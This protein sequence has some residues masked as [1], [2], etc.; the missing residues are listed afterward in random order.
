MH[1]RPELRP[2]RPRR[3]LA[4]VAAAVALAVAGG[5]AL[6]YAAAAPAR[7]PLDQLASAEL[8]AAVDPGTNPAGD[9]G[10][11][12]PAAQVRECVRQH[13]AANDRP[14][15]RDCLKGLRGLVRARGAL[16]RAVHGDLI[17]RNKAGA[18]EPVTFD[19][20]TVASKADGTVSLERPDGV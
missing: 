4:L 13:R 15:V 6:A 2:P 11:A 8:V 3:K 17:V 10:A 12:G 16:G 5:G 19:R 14:G 9:T 7:P 1:T 20:G 18:Y